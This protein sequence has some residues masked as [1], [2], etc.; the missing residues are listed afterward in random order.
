MIYN[1][2]KGPVEIWVLLYLGPP[3]PSSKHRITLGKKMFRVP[4]GE[5]AALRAHELHRNLKGPAAIPMWDEMREATGDE[6]S[7]YFR[8][9]PELLVK[10]SDPRT[11]REK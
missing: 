2:S 3:T 11:Y 1:T 5:S 6:V 8:S 9:H 10:N 4:E 7:L